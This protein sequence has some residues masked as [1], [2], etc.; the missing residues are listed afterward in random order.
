MRSGSPR[1]RGAPLFRPIK[2]LLEKFEIGSVTSELE[3]HERLAKRSSI[4][5]DSPTRRTAT[6]PYG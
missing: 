3:I 2:C 5:R 4:V 6:G 1:R